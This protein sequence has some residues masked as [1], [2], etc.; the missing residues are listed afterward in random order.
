[1]ATKSGRFIDKL[2]AAAQLEPVKREVHLETGTTVVFYSSPLTAAERERSKKQARS[3]D[4]HALALQLL[5]TKAKDEA[6][7]PLFTP[8]DEATL[9]REVRD[10]DLQQLMLAVMGAQDEGEDL[11]M[12]SSSEG[13]S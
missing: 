6:G 8:G 10:A 12:K 2:V 11:D 3:E 7:M 4:A 9:Q 5:I 13:A 1:M